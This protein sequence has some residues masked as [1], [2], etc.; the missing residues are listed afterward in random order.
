V[1]ASAVLVLS[2]LIV[3]GLWTVHQAKERT[4]P[5][6]APLSEPLRSGR[7]PATTPPGRP[8][9]AP[10]SEPLRSSPM[11]SS[12]RM[13]IGIEFKAIHEHLSVASTQQDY[14][15]F[16]PLECERASKL[17]WTYLPYDWT[18]TIKPDLAKRPLLKILGEKD[19]HPI[20]PA[21]FL[22]GAFNIEEATPLLIDLVTTRFKGGEWPNYER[23]SVLI[24]TFQALGRLAAHGDKRAANFLMTRS[25]LGAWREIPYSIAGLDQKGSAFYAWYRLCDALV[26][27]PCEDSIKALKEG[28]QACSAVNIAA[29]RGFLAS[30]DSLDEYYREIHGTNDPLGVD[31]RRNS[32]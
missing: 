14:D 19:T 21:A 11:T 6:M 15:E 16:I 22:V 2:V 8:Q 7:P 18:N 10:L 25:T 12:Q 23:Q 24:G 26:Y 31:H 1:S 4:G 32:P 30:G 9:I 28:G 20:A 13:A 3:L 29:I 27:Y 17:M 5:R